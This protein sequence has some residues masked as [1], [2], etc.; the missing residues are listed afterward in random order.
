M[1]IANDFADGKTY[2]ST[3]L[4]NAKELDF[5]PHA[6]FKGVYLKLLVPG[7]MTDGQISS[8][9]VKVDPH[10]VLDT[11]IH[12]NNLEIHEV[13]SGSAK[14]MV[15]DK[16][17]DYLPGTIGVLPAGVPHKIVAG[18]EGVYI[19]AKFTPALV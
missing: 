19:L 2:T 8:H 9:L 4:R 10:C 18:E 14:A 15:G 16:E 6:K 5:V 1:N 12:E 17:V 11:H 13:I 7:A 3:D